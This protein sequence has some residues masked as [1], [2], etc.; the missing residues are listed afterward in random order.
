MTLTT[1]DT[2]TLCDC[3]AQMLAND[4]DSSCRDYYGHTHDSLSV[5]ADTVLTD[6]WEISSTPWAC[7]GCGERQGSFS[8]RHAADV[9]GH[10]LTTA[11]HDGDD[12]VPHVAAESVTVNGRPVPLLTYFEFLGYLREVVAND[13]DCGLSADD[14]N[15]HAD[16]MTFYLPDYDE[17][18]VYPKFDDKGHDGLPRYAVDGW[19]WMTYAGP[20]FACDH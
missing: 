19:E 7:D 18:E 16:R 17:T 11:P 2:L 13:P 9:L 6:E 20:C 4:D 12:Y 5:P 10:L 14:L 8:P 15:H 3:C 1:I